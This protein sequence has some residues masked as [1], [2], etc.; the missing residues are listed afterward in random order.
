MSRH[1]PYLPSFTSLALLCLALGWLAPS[2][3]AAQKRCEPCFSV[4]YFTVNGTGTGKIRNDHH[5]LIATVGEIEADLTVSTDRSLLQGFSVATGFW[6]YYL[7]EPLSPMVQATDGDFLERVELSWEVPDQ[8]TGPPV[9]GTKATIVRNGTQLATVD[10]I[11]GKKIYEY[12]DFNVFPG[13]EYEYAILTT[14]DLGEAHDD[15]DVGFLTPNGTILGNI[16]TRNGNPAPDVKVVLTP[17]LGRSADFTVDDYIYFPEML[18]GVEASYTIEGWFR[19]ILAQEQTLF[20]AV[21]SAT[22]RPFL[23]IQLN[24]FGELVWEHRGDSSAE[25]DVVTTPVPYTND[26]EWHHFAAVLAD[27]NNSMT[28]YVDGRIVARDTADDLIGE[29]RAQVVMGKLGPVQ[30][31]Q[32]YQGR[33]DDWRIWSRPKSRPQVRQ[34]MDRTLEGDEEGLTAYWKFDEVKGD[35]TFDL[36]LN[37]ND[38]VICGVERSQFLAPVFVS[39]ITDEFGNYAMRGVFY[40]AGRTFTATPQKITPI[41]RSLKFDGVDDFVGYP[42]RRLDLTGGYTIEGW[43]KHPGGN[44]PHAILS[45]VNPVDDSDQMRLELLDDGR[46]QVTQMGAAVT[47]VDRYDVE[48]WYHFA[49]THDVGDGAL[50]LYVDGVEVAGGNAPAV[51]TLSA[52]VIGKQAPKIDA[53][54]YVGW[55]DEFRIWDRARTA[56]QVGAVVNQ[57]LAG[58]ETGMVAY[59]KMNEGDGVL[60]TDATGNGQTGEIFHEVDV[61]GDPVILE[62]G[63]ISKLARWTDD[64]PLNENFVNTFEPESRQVTLNSG[65]TVVQPVDFTDISLIGVSGFVKYSKTACFISGAEILIN[66]QSQF[67]PY[68]TDENGKFVV[69]FEPGARNQQLSVKVT[70][71]PDSVITPARILRFIRCHAPYTAFAASSI[72]LGGSTAT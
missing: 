17:S 34:D 20:A 39:A 8:R 49:F 41:G 1:H 47:S 53:Q 48:F 29:Q 50:K 52:Y 45:T 4:P 69:E 12:Q 14:N 24:D 27:S 43:F 44:G 11:Q 71:H 3:A 59:W 51:P 19:S 31:E 58:N 32:Y 22:T 65:N 54:Y 23:R 56:E 10:L 68:R 35:I 18:Q 7:T 25:S 5:N 46:L 64:I 2:S 16:E 21:D 70:D 40:G 33:L 37:D 72:R 38:G 30:H 61:Q 36:T 60:L 67:P 9:K 63:L 42:R 28:L 13:E 55:M 6:G 26:S 62:N 66:G 57:V 15:L